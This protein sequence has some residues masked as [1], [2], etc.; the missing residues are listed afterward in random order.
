M[1]T[2]SRSCVGPRFAAH[3]GPSEIFRLSLVLCIASVPV[4]AGLCH[5]AMKISA[6]KQRTPQGR[7]KKGFSV[8]SALLRKHND[9]FPSVDQEDFLILSP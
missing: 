6:V 1:R 3:N 2:A 8:E 4:K 5:H 9:D 7:E